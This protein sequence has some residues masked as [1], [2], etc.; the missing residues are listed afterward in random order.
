MGIRN[1]DNCSSLVKNDNFNKKRK[2]KILGRKQ[3]KT[4]ESSENSSLQSISKI[5]VR[6]IY[7]LNSKYLRFT[8]YLR[9]NFL[10]FQAFSKGRRCYRNWSS[11]K[12]VSPHSFRTWIFPSPLRQTSYW[13]LSQL[14]G[15][16]KSKT[17]VTVEKIGETT[18][19]STKRTNQRTDQ[20][21]RTVGRITSSEVGLVRMSSFSCFTGLVYKMP[22]I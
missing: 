1:W 10:I 6:K 12:I 11:D 7:R 2:T 3:T 15:S 9:F 16:R 18:Q 19:R 14:A 5:L 4:R 17:E 13:I 22:V 8:V 21:M 20:R